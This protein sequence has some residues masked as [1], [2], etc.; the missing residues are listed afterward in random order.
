MRRINTINLPIWL[1]LLLTKIVVYSTWNPTSYNFLHY[2]IMSDASFSSRALLA[3]ALLAV[4]AF[5]L[6]ETFQSFNWYGIIIFMGLIAA[7]IWKAIDWGLVNASD[8]NIWQWLAPAIVST[9]FTLGLIGPRMLRWA[10]GR[11]PVSARV[12]H[13]GSV[14]DHH[15]ADTP[16]H[17]S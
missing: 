4:Y 1:A 12:D 7:M 15:M 8:F 11:V 16:T 17:H 5:Y 3:I 9:F 6:N 13:D 14:V 10:T 2:I